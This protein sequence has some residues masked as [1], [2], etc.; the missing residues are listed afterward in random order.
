LLNL[1]VLF[2]FRI[3]VL[4][5]GRGKKFFEVLLSYFSAVELFEKNG[6]LRISSKE[7]LLEG[8]KISIF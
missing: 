7:G 3:D 5:S 8:L 6:C 4:C 2:C 1:E